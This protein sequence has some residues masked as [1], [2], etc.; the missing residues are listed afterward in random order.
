MLF[1]GGANGKGTL[2][3]LIEEFLGRTNCSHRSLQDLDS[4]R[5]AVADL[6]GKLANLFAD[7]KSTK[8]TETVDR[9]TGEHNVVSH[10]NNAFL[11]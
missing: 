8:L 9:Y 1:G 4:N 11:Q 2:L 7:L 3:K 10:T 5:L 6:H